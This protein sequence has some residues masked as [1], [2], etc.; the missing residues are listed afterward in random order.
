M[1]G[2]WGLV[3]DGE[4]GSWDSGWV[5][6]LGLE[7]AGRAVEFLGFLDVDVE[8]EFCGGGDDLGD[9]DDEGEEDTAGYLAHLFFYGRAK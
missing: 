6:G 4:G 1:L 7:L 8:A 9:G 2:F 3:G 5:S